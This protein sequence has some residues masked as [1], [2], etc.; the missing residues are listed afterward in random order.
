M[1]LPL[2]LMAAI[3]WQSSNVWPGAGRF[4]LLL[5]TWLPEWLPVDKVV[6]AAMYALLCGAWVFAL[7]PWRQQWHLAAWA[8]TLTA[9]YGALDEVHQSF[10]PGR[11]ADPLDALADAAGALIIALAVWLVGRR[12]R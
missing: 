2:G 7:R 9:A 11:T 1:A 4:A 10:V 12:G 8:W 5:A 3:W 6:H